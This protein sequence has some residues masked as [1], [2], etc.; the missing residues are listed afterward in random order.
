MKRKI[1]PAR[2]KQLIEQLKKARA[3]RGA[4][5]GAA[6]G[7]KARK[8]SAKNPRKKKRSKTSV[9]RTRGSN[10]IRHTPL[11][12]IVAQKGAGPK[13]HFNGM[14]FTTNGKPAFFERHQ[15]QEVAD[16]LVKKYPHVLGGYKLTG[17]PVKGTVSGKV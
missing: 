1:T 16:G 8:K 11:Y 13:M 14:N 10:P 17:V 9:R 12:I 6:H 5:R 4:A 3:A 7:T 15:L 2:R